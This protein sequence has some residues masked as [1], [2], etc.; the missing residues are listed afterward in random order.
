MLNCKSTLQS[1][2][3]F[4]FFLANPYIKKNQPG[5]SFIHTAHVQEKHHW[6]KTI[7]VSVAIWTGVLKKTLTEMWGQIGT[8]GATISQFCQSLMESSQWQSGNYSM[9]CFMH[10]WHLFCHWL[11][12]CKER[13]IDQWEKKVKNISGTGKCLLVT[14]RIFFFFLD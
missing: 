1:A 6:F 8:Q 12:P 10:A 4:L 2:L 9:S 11:C 7:S 5:H 3:V 13:N 14:S